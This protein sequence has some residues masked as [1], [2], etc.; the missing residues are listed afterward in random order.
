MI[1]RIKGYVTEPRVVEQTFEIFTSSGLGYEIKT[2]KETAMCVASAKF[3]ITIYTHYCVKEDSAILYG[4]LDI[5][6]RDIFRAL[7]S[8]KGIGK[9]IALEIIGSVGS[10]N[11]KQAVDN[12]DYHLFTLAKGV[13]KKM[14]EKISSEL[15]KIL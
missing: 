11:I 4:F 15:P 8:I 14:I 3:E 10:E 2:D 5:E 12:D 1:S 7:I 6:T 13:G 9:L